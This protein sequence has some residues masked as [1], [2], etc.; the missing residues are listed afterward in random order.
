MKYVIVLDP[1]N[2][3]FNRFLQTY[4]FNLGYTRTITYLVTPSVW[5]IDTINFTIYCHNTIFD[6][7]YMDN[8]KY[9][10]D[11]SKWKE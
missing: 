2:V 5:C 6:I 8:V 9:I 10:I 7:W 3:Q 4:F 1:Q 11:L